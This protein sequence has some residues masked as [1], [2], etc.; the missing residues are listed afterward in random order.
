MFKHKLTDFV[1][2]LSL[3]KIAELNRA[4]ATALDLPLPVS[5]WVVG[6]GVTVSLRLAQTPHGPLDMETHRRATPA[7][8]SAPGNWGW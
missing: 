1:G 2:T 8:F 5:R 6:C 3:T 7:L 4:L